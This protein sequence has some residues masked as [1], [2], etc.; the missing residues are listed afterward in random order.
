MSDA[1]REDQLRSLAESGPRLAACQDLHELVA[2]GTDLGRRIVQAT[3]ASI[4]RIEHD[5]GR[6]RVLHNVG[7]LADWE[8][9]WPQDETY[10]LGDFPLLS[11]TVE[12]A[13]PWVGH[14]EEDETPAGQ[15]HQELLRAMN[16]VSS[17]SI[18]IIV[19]SR[20]W[21]ELGASRREGMPRYDDLD[22]AAG[23]SFAALFAAS[24][25]RIEEEDELRT[26]A[27]LDPLTGLGNRRALDQRLEAEFSVALEDPRPIALILCD[28]DGLKRI[29]DLSGHDGGDLVLRE[30]ATRITAAAGQHAQSLAARLGGDEFAVLLVGVDDAEVARLTQALNDEASSLP[31]GAGLSCGWASHPRTDLGPADAMSN[32]RGL[33]RL[34][35]AAQYRSKRLGR[36]TGRPVS[37]S[38][39]GR[40]E[41]GEAAARLTR[42]VLR[43]LDGVEDVMARLDVVVRA[44]CEVVDASGGAV[45]A[46]LDGGPMIVISNVAHDRLTEPARRSI[47]P[48]VTF[49]LDDFPQS[50]A[51]L[52]GG[53][54][55][56]DLDHG[57]P[58]EQAFLATHGHDELIAAGHRQDDAVAWLVEVFGDAMSVPLA[59]FVSLLE[60]LMA[61]A[62]QGGRAA[63]P[64]EVTGRL[65]EGVRSS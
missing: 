16:M 55:H 32:A 27:F 53:A 5:T 29:N 8:E 45:S 19:G 50:R 38:G 24:V 41:A 26:L 4:A 61:L 49:D 59:P 42:L 18:P 13:A 11:A 63:R 25:R 3:A 15:A 1:R 21:G 6:L 64:A 39:S 23:Q 57:D 58:S 2:V 43:K 30:V 22:V 14:L 10:D 7:E 47:E 35:D 62:V 40:F 31:L 65:P 9:P 56:A 28:V 12:G 33:L 48:G 52:G 20:V 51:V 17:I 46:S 60:A 37:G 34:A 36:G 44:C 54:F